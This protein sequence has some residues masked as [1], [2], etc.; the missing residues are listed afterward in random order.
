MRS[1]CYHC[2]RFA[3][4][5]VVHDTRSGTRIVGGFL[6]DWYSNLQILVIGPFGGGEVDLCWK[7]K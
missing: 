4:F 5:S 6:M 3:N 7:P 1:T 2:E